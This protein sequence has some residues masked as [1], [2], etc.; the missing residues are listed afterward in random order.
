LLA[1]IAGLRAGAAPSAGPSANGRSA[2]VAGAARVS[3]LPEAELR[4]V[5]VL[6]CDVAGY[7]K[8]THEVGA[9]TMHATG[10]S[11]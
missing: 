6:F 10:F 4:Q 7:T 11:S 9:E 8:L 2:P 5:T 3:R 1:A